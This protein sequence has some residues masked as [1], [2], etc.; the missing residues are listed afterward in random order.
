MRTHH[1]LAA[2]LLLVAGGLH[3][4]ADDEFEKLMAEFR[5]AQMAY[6]QALEAEEGEKPADP[7]AVFMPKFRELA[8]KHAGSEVELKALAFLVSSPPGRTRAEGES[9][10]LWALK[11]L[12]DAHAANPAIAEVLPQM[13]FGVMAIGRPAM[14]EL[15]ERIIK[16]NK[17]ADAV[18][19]ARL[20]LA[21]TLYSVGPHGSFEQPPRGRPDDVKR[22]TELFR[23]IVAKHP[24]ARPAE[25]AARY[26]FEIENLQP[27]MKAP[28][29]VGK[30]ADGK[31]IRLSQFRGKLV[32]LDFWGFW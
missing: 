13:F 26:L 31:E 27:G 14:I 24:G 23:E 9:D 8:E 2:A 3:A 1:F 30:D 22:A 6:W 21:V 15:Y 29:I 17:D 11:R 4:R 10:A 12:S 20:S 19:A 25:R 32:Y 18:A 7:A 16:E 5:A 28:E